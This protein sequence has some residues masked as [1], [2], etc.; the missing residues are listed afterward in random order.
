VIFIVFF[1]K[2]KINDWNISFS[3]FTG[4]KGKKSFLTFSLSSKASSFSF[5]FV[6][7]FK[8]VGGGGKTT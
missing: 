7:L 6:S 5:N 1:Q 3:I 2:P 8:G 4:I